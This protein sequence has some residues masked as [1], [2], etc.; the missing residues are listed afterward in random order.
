[1]NGS[2]MRDLGRWHASKDREADAHWDDDDDDE[3]TQ[4]EDAEYEQ[5]LK[6][7]RKRLLNK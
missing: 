5:N 3:D 4:E 2:D 7:M 1:M 6:L